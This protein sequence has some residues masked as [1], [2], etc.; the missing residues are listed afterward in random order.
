MLFMSLQSYFPVKSSSAFE[1]LIHTS[2]PEE[3]SA[4]SI[5]ISG[6]NDGYVICWSIIDTT[7]QFRLSAHDDSVISFILFHR[8]KS[9]YI[10]ST[11]KDA[12]VKICD[13]GSQN[14][15]RTIGHHRAEVYRIQFDLKIHF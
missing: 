9:T 14:F 6:S 1:S 2:K 12:L 13:A 7:G 5:F 15:I 10:M 4:P 8:E 3:I 11:F